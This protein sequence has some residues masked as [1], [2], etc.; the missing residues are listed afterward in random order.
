MPITE[1]Q[2]EKLFQRGKIALETAAAVSETVVTARAAAA[3]AETRAPAACP[4]VL[5]LAL[6]L[7]ELRVDGLVGLA[8]DP[9][10]VLGLASVVLGEEGVGG[11]FPIG[12]VTKKWEK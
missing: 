9:D 10:Q 3:V 6:E 8:E 11:A 5:G 7:E 1:T 12:P 4:Y 2:E